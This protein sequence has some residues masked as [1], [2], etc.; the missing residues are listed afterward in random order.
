[1]TEKYLTIEEAFSVLLKKPG[2]GYKFKNLV[3][4]IIDQCKKYNFSIL[5]TE[6][7]TKKDSIYFAPNS[8]NIVTTNPYSVFY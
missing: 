3:Q 1:M 2:D 5:Q 7:I 8:E 4:P 6:P